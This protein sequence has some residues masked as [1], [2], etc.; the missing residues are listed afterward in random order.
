M[1]IEIVSFQDEFISDA[2]ELL[3]ARHASDRQVLPN[4]PPRFTDPF[5]AR[6][7]IAATLRRPHASGVAAL[8]GGQL[9]GYLIGEM[10]FDPVWGRQGWVR[11]PGSALAPDQPPHRIHDLYTVLGA[12]WVAAGCFEHFALVSAA[13][14]ALIQ[15]WFALSFGLQQI[16]ALL[17]LDG[18]DLA[19]PAAPPGITIR[20]AGPGD[21]AALADMSDVIWRHQTQAPVWAI[22]LPETEAET[23]EGW[24]E[25]VDDPTVM[26]WLAFAQDQVVGSLGYWPVDAADD[27][28]HIPESCVRMSIAG[29]REVVRGRGVMQAMTHHGLALVRERGYRFCETDW[30]STNTLA[31]RFWPRQGFHPS[32]Y[33]LVRRIDPRIT[34]ANGHG[35]RMDAAG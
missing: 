31:A 27:A 17:A 26:A 12:H 9:L 29:T 6:A 2:A 21:R 18:L 24:A 10:V 7:A 22:H 19:R 34:W 15:A 4:L 11:L 30:R 16:Y 35:R 32:V 1:P 20:Q 8:Q 3:A 13:D 5:A 28:M 23:R 33:R 25:L 14:P